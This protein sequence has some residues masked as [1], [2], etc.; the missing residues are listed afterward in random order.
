MRCLAIHNDTAGRAP[1]SPHLVAA[2]PV[3][4]HSDDITVPD[5]AVRRTFLTIPPVSFTAHHVIPD[6][7][8]KNQ[9]GDRS[10]RG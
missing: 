8:W 3:D 9:S 2:R 6:A 10:I 4:P 1:I 7:T 5:A